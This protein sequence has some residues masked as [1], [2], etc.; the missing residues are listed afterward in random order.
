MYQTFM[1]SRARPI[2]LAVVVLLVTLFF[3]TNIYS[4]HRISAADV[5]FLPPADGSTMRVIDAAVDDLYNNPLPDN[6][7]SFA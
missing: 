2:V 6:A 7:S 1:K 3:Y 5:T 4:T